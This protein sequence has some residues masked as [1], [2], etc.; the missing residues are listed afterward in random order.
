M[1]SS[2]SSFSRA[3]DG[4]FKI[5]E[6]GS[7][8]GTEIKGAGRCGRCGRPRALSSALRKRGQHLALVP[9]PSRM[10]KAQP[11]TEGL[12]GLSKKPHPTR[13]DPPPPA[14]WPPQPASAPS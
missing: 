3:L 12:Q 2:Q 4:Y 8:I 13:R 1:A 11:I 14:G 7:T 5:T 10:H 6:R 9:G